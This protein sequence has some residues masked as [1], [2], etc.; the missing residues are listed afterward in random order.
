MTEYCREWLRAIPGK[1]K[2]EDKRKHFVWS[3]WLTVGA[4]LFLTVGE[5]FV[6][7][8][9]IGLAKEFWDELYGSGF[10]FYDVAAN[11]LGSFTALAGA[12]AVRLMLSAF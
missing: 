7:V 2:E 11:L 6:V 12:L 8:F 4:L 5:A 3:F 10:C 1:I 9:L